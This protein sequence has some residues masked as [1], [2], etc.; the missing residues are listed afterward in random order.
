MRITESQLRKVI[1][2]IISEQAETVA[3]AADESWISF[4]D[5][6]KLLDGDL[7][8][9]YWY[10]VNSDISIDDLMD[11]VIEKMS[12]DEDIKG[13]FFAQ[14][15]EDEEL[16]YEKLDEWFKVNQVDIKNYLEQQVADGYDPEPSDDTER[17]FGSE[18][19]Y[20]RYRNG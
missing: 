8:K 4:S 17:I 14:Y 20:W 6:E 9:Q 12:D 7:N 1:K 2:K 15:G 19:G 3:P 16:F 13:M 10:A 11:L 18:A 5:I